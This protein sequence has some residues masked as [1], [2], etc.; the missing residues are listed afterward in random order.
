MP[1]VTI[2]TILVIY[3][4]LG[5]WGGAQLAYLQEAS[6]TKAFE[7]TIS[8][9]ALFLLFGLWLLVLRHAGIGGRHPGRRGDKLHDLLTAVLGG[10]R[11]PAGTTATTTHESSERTLG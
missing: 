8:G 11:G 9:T 5:R 6:E 4:V 1:L 10:P 3:F 2:F 7:Q